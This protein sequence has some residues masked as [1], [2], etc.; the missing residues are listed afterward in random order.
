MTDSTQTTAQPPQAKFSP[1]TGG[2]YLVGI[3]SAVPTDAIDVTAADY[4]ALMAAQAK[5]AT[6]RADANGAPEAVA[7]NGAVIDLT[8]V[9]TT[10]TFTY[11]PPITL[12]QQAATAFSA[13]SDLMWDEYG[14]LGETPPTE[15]TT[16]LKAL[17]AI[18]S[19]TDTTSTALPPAPT[20]NTS[21][22]TA[23]TTTQTATTTT[24]QAAAAAT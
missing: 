5:G 11:A 20:D 16:Y 21:G 23:S 7:G 4:A 8:T 6:I 15:W 12:Q 9:T 3:S 13:A 10:A 18:A 19:G 1:A 17:R 14:C 22:T 2:F 24:A